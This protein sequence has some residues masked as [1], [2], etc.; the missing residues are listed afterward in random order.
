MQLTTEDLKRGNCL[1]MA[2][3]KSALQL[4]AAV[5]EHACLQCKEFSNMGISFAPLPTRK[6]RNCNKCYADKADK[7]L[8]TTKGKIIIERYNAVLGRLNHW[9]EEMSR[10]RK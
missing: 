8:K 9:R 3:K 6:Y 7:F 2:E 4:Q 5:C 10:D 1:I